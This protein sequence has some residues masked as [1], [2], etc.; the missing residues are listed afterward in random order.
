[1]QDGIAGNGVILLRAENQTDGGI[2]SVR[3]V[4]LLVKTDVTI[5]L[6]DVLMGKLSYFEI[7]QYNAFE[8]I[9]VK[10]EVDKEILVGKADALLTRDEGKATA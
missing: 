9:V 10:H 1:V 4:P 2:I 8:Q 5:H 7:D 6:A 3:P